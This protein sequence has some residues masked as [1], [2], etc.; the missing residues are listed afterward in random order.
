MDK[1]IGFL[2]YQSCGNRGSVGLVFVLRWCMWVVGVVLGQG[3]EGCVG[4]CLC[5]L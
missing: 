3:L 1:K 4:L 5:D 2:L